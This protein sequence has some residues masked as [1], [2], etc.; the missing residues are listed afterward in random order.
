M[1]VFEYACLKSKASIIVIRIL[2]VLY[3]MAP[4]DIAQPTQPLV[5]PLLVA[6]RD[7]G[8]LLGSLQNGINIILRLLKR[9]LEIMQ[10]L[11]QVCNVA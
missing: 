1:S 4:L 10:L 2:R 6:S 3:Q 9:G 7:L 8:I 11:V 5:Q